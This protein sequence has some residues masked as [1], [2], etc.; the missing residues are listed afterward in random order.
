MEFHLAAI[1]L[2]TFKITT[3]NLMLL[4][5]SYNI[6]NLFLSILFVKSVT[7]L[8]L[9]CHLWHQ[10]LHQTLH[11]T[12]QLLTQ[13]YR[14]YVPI[15]STLVRRI[16]A[17]RCFRILLSVHTV[18][19]WKIILHCI[20]CMKCNE[21]NKRAEM[22]V[23]RAVFYDSEFGVRKSHSS[24]GDGRLRHIH[25]VVIGILAISGAIQ[26]V[27]IEYNNVTCN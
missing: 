15:L 9:L 4:K 24:K 13:I 7:Y 6:N 17:Y 19:V 22:T 27:Y 10:F 16:F 1:M 18:R 25:I 23:N 3:N 8:D 2:S 11:F 26:T 21:Q 12:G 5:S 20:T 14:F